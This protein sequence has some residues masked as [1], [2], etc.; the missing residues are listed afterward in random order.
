LLA[1]IAARS[2]ASFETR[3]GFSVGIV[4]TTP[5]FPYT[6]KQVDEPVGLPVILAGPP[7]AEDL[8]NVHFGEVGLDSGVLVTSGLYG[9]TWSSPALGPTSRR[10]GT[11]PTGERDGSSSRAFATGST[12]ASA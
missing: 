3:P 12:S 7:S 1:G 10:P 8:S 6:R 5:P 9:W 2:A 11:P 4:L